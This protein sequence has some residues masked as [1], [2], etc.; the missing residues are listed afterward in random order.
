LIFGRACFV[1]GTKLY[2]V[3]SLDGFDLAVVGIGLAALVLTRSY[4]KKLFAKP[5]N[6]R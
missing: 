6:R 1:I 2:F 4:A 3:G 5:T